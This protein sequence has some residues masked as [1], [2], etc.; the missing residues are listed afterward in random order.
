[1][2]QCMYLASNK[3]A[4][5][6]FCRVPIRDTRIKKPGNLIRIF[7]GMINP[8]YPREAYNAGSYGHYAFIHSN[9]PNNLFYDGHV[10]LRD[11][12]GTDNWEYWFQWYPW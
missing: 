11:Y 10:K 1:M 9:M 7:D 3:A 8:S 4:W 6:V 5:A 2:V 12:G